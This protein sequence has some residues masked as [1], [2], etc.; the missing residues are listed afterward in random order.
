MESQGRKQGE[1]QVLAIVLELAT[2]LDQAQDVGARDHPQKMPVFDYG[3][4][5]DVLLRHELKDLPQVLVRRNGV[6][7]VDRRHRFFDR[8]ERPLVARDVADV[9]KR[10]EPNKVVAGLHGE[11]ADVA[12]QDI[13]VDDVST[14]SFADDLAVLRGG[15]APFQAAASSRSFAVAANATLRITR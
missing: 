5:V 11:A 12:Q 10:D 9:L 8:G 3:D 6:Q 2:C 14:D 7:T 1:T 13:V 15:V 4:L